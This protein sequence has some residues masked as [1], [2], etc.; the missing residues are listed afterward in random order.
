MQS[1]YADRWGTCLK[2]ISKTMPHV[3]GK[4]YIDGAYDKN[5]EHAVMELYDD[6][7][8]TYADRMDHVEWMTDTVKAAAK[9]KMLNMNASYYLPEEVR[10]QRDSPGLLPNADS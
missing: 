9:D 4:M 10:S 2:H 5:Q 1:S 7:R 6:L 8:A 3:A